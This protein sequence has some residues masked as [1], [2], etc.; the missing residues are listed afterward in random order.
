[1]TSIIQLPRRIYILLGILFSLWSLGF[2]A[3]TSFVAI[4]GNRYFSLFEDAMIS[5]RYAW[6]LSHGQ[7]L[8]WNPG[9]RIEGYTNLLMTLLMSIFTALFPKAQAVL[10]VQLLSIPITLVN[11]ILASRIASLLASADGMSIENRNL[12]GMLAFICTL[13]CYPLAYW[14]L[15]GMETGLLTTFLLLA[16]FSAIRYKFQPDLPTFYLVSLALSL[17]YLTRPDSL[18]LALVIFAYTTWTAHKRTSLRELAPMIITQLLIILFF[19]CGQLAFRYVYYGELVPNTYTLKISGISIQDRVINGLHF[20]YPFLYT[21]AIPIYIALSGLATK[22]SAEKILL[23]LSFIIMVSYQVFIG[24]DPW[25]YWRIVAPTLPLLL[26]LFI[27]ATLRQTSQEQRH[28]IEPTPNASWLHIFVRPYP[29]IAAKILFV[30]IVLNGLFLPEILLIRKPYSTDSY[31]R[32]INTAIA[33]D[34]VLDDQATVGVFWAGIIPY[35]SGRYS[36]DFLGKADAYIARVQ[37]DLSG[38]TGWGRM[39][40]APGH[41]K[42]DLDFSI[43][44]KRPTYIQMARWGKQ[45]VETWVREN[46]VTVEYNDVR[47]LLDKTSRHVNWELVQVV[48]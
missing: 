39:I 2:I 23:L 47:L 26:I 11:A 6:N 31:E 13:C 4:D 10:G 35:F 1:M 17:A 44:E 30:M 14:T 37:P 8:V 45:N 20:I 19:V 12:I 9:E 24:G 27:T 16:L 22:I 7:G 28:K 15:M 32:V 33:L 3:R 41:N 18:L 48:Q 5:M 38:A 34:H 42:Y 43:I 46:Y 36:V 40:Y 21:V 29:V 25:D